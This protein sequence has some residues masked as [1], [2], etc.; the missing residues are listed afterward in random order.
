MVHFQRRRDSPRRHSVPSATHQ[1][2]LLWVARKMTADGLIVAGLDGAVPQG[3]TWNR[4]ARPFQIAGVRPD[5]WAFNPSNG[6]IALGEAK[7]A[8]DLCNEHTLSQ[9]RTFG[10]LMQRTPRQ[11]CRLYIAIPQSAAHL[12][13]KLLERARLPRTDGVVRLHV[14]DCLVAEQ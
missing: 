2:L 11:L 10:S 5:A 8:D 1:S 12:L 9:V 13:D 3:G 6:G 7:T 14:P 4:L